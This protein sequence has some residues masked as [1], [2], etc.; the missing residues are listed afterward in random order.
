MICRCKIKPKPLRYSLPQC[1]AGA[2]IAILNNGGYMFIVNGHL[3]CELRWIGG[4]FSNRPILTI[5]ASCSTHSRSATATVDSP[6]TTGLATSTTLDGSPVIRS[7]S[8]LGKAALNLEGDIG[9]TFVV[10]KLTS[11]AAISRLS[12]RTSIANFFKSAS[13]FSPCSSNCPSIENNAKGSASDT[14]SGFV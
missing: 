3:Q 6:P 14:Q 13:V 11:L 1:Q 9:G 10:S 4:Y 8:K 12:C 7:S 5:T 2:L